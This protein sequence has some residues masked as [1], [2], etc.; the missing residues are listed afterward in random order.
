MIAR[1]TINDALAVYSRLRSHNQGDYVAPI[2]EC[3]WSR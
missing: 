1:G 2:D 3:M